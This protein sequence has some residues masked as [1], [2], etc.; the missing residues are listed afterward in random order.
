[1][2]WLATA[3]V[4]KNKDFTH[5]PAPETG[6]TTN[7]DSLNLES[8]SEQEDP[9]PQS[10]VSLGPAVCASNTSGTTSSPKEEVTG[11]RCCTTCGSEETISGG[12]VVS[13]SSTR[14]TS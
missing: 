7:F 1:M 13:T 14:C 2:K 11:G 6:S 4:D 10:P 3:L 9:V 5:G 8:G 12:F